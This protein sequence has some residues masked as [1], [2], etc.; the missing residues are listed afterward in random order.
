MPCAKPPSWCSQVD[1]ER[2]LGRTLALQ[3]IPAPTFREQARAGF[4]ESEFAKAGLAEIHFDATGNLLGKVSGGSRPPLLVCAHLDSVF[5][6]DASLPALRSG[7]QLWGPGIGDNAIG[8]ATLVELAIDLCHLAPKGDVWLVGTVCEEGLGNLRGMRQVVADFGRNVAAYLAL[9]GMA[10][11]HVYHRGLPAQ[12]YRISARTAGGHSWIHAGRPSAVHTLLGLGADLVRAPL[13]SP[14]RTVLN[15]GRIQGG[16]SVNTIASDA[17]FEVDLRSEDAATLKAL[18]GHVEALVAGF[19]APGVTLRMEAIGE[20]PAGGLSDSHPL[21]RAACEALKEAG[22]RWIV[23][24]GSTDASVPLSL[25]LP[26]V[27]VGLTRGGGAHSMKEHI[28]IS[29]LSRGYA[30]VMGLIHKVFD[31]PSA[32]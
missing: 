10:L 18:A 5:P 16:T 19:Q 9:E 22:E 17:S 31:L 15:I 7:D 26:A 24:A 6:A 30:A 32:G 23:E 25:G 2:L 3:A 4:L 21:V 29:P 1:L 13:S 20:R 11:G 14:P 28:Q 27:C 8:L 12:R